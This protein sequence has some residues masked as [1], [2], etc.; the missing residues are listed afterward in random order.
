MSPDIKICVSSRPWNVYEDAFGGDPSRMLRLQDLTRGDIRLYVT[1]NLETN[2]HYLAIKEVDDAYKQLVEEI[3][4]RADGV[5]LWV[6]LVVRELLHGLTNH[7]WIRDLQV[8]LRRLPPDLKKYFRYIMDSVEKVYEESSARILQICI[9]AENPL[10]IADLALLDEDDEGDLL[11]NLDP[12]S[13][14]QS[15][16]QIKCLDSTKRLNARCKGLVEVGSDPVVPGS[17]VHFLHR[18]VRDFLDT[19]DIQEYLHKR[20]SKTFCPSKALLDISLATM[21]L[22]KLL[23]EQLVMESLM[24]ACI[25]YV[26]HTK[27]L[28]RQ[29]RNATLD[30]VGKEFFQFGTKYD[31]AFC[32]RYSALELAIARGLCTFIRLSIA[33]P[34]GLPGG[35]L[36]VR[37][38]LALTLFPPDSNGSDGVE[39]P[40]QD[41]HY[42]R[43]DMVQ[44]L[45]SEGADLNICPQDSYSVYSLYTLWIDLIRFL[46]NEWNDLPKDTKDELRDITTLFFQHG[47][48]PDI[49]VP[50]GIHRMS[51]LRIAL[52]IVGCNKKDMR[53]N[54]KTPQAVKRKEDGKSSSGTNDTRKDDRA[55][56]AMK[57][58]NGLRAGFDTKKGIRLGVKGRL[59]SIAS[60]ILNLKGYRI[61]TRRIRSSLPRGFEYVRPRNTHTPNSLFPSNPSLD[62]SVAPEGLNTT[63]VPQGTDEMTLQTTT[64]WNFHGLDSRT[65]QYDRHPISSVQPHHYTR[66]TQLIISNDH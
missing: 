56:R 35:T 47:A 32:Y 20:A 12:K 36:S 8:R 23:R 45:L 33:G 48:D 52:D 6:F 17:S 42:F 29:N 62:Y 27:T 15:S 19:P 64:N 43:S 22:A 16:I 11:E 30:L 44:L 37:N 1:D 24:R 34:T 61:S 60:S 65:S 21:R 58:G 9:H 31:P 14:T 41:I 66:E 46:G 39:T 3:T 63:M 28:S 7:D 25:Y 10:T 26:L 2:S 38:R 18:T 40:S 50:V 57:E 59:A 5:F 4:E 53:K 13:W 55:I 49:E 51:A 54:I